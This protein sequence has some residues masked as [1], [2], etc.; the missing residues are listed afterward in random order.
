MER[1]FGEYSPVVSAAFPTASSAFPTASNHPSSDSG[2][3]RRICIMVEPSPFSYICG[4]V[5]Q[6][7]NLIRYLRE[8]GCEVRYI[9]VLVLVVAPPPPYGR[10]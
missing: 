7:T 3:P 9:L 5:N 2:V 10:T 4:Y 8:E 1:I 6:F